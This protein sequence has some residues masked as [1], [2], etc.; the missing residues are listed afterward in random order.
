MSLG[1]YHWS[2]VLENGH[3]ITQF[4]D[5]GKELSID[6]VKKNHY[7]E[8][9]WIL[10]TPINRSSHVPIGIGVLPGENWS[11]KWVR[12]FEV[13]TD[14]N[15]VPISKTEGYVID[16]L[17]ITPIDSKTPVNIYIY[18]DGDVKITTETE[19]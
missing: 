10:L 8:V 18:V 16:A 1:Y 13:T 2:V 7:S 4:T 17:S 3:V 14:I 6:Y 5:E 19:P 9:R 12:T 11:K 15:G